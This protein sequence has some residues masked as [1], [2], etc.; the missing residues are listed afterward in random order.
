MGKAILLSAEIS[1]GRALI[2]GGGSGRDVLEQ[3]KRWMFGA[4]AR[5]SRRLNASLLHWSESICLAVRD[6]LPLGTPLGRLL[7]EIQPMIR[8]EERHWRRLQ[9]L[10]RQFGFQG[11]IA[12][13]LPWAVAGLSGGVQFNFF[14]F[15]GAVFQILGLI[16]FY[17]VIN[18]ATR[19]QVDESAWVFDLLVAGWMRVLAGMSLHNALRSSLDAV[20]SSSWHAAWKNWVRAYEGGSFEHHAFGWP[21][22]MK[23]SG[24]CAQ[25][26]IA[27]LKSGSPAAETLADLI[28]QLDDDRQAE[29]E[30]RLN[31]VPTKLSLTFCGFF[32]PAVFLILLGTLWPALKDLSI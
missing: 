27:L 6:A 18:R 5:G 32:T 3:L 15:A 2:A 31:T 11:G 13:V 7:A 1:K 9:A 4:P 20:E 14:T 10:E 25:L 12:V 17:F 29:L 19:R 24:D 22:Q 8:R 26:F 30:E 28:A 23:V 21:A 16:A